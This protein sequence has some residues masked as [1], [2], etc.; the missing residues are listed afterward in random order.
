[1]EARRVG[2]RVGVENRVGGSGPVED[3]WCRASGGW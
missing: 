2:G 3:G 1:M